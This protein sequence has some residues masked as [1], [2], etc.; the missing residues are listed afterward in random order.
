MECGFFWAVDAEV[1]EPTRNGLDSLAFL[2]GWRELAEVK[3]TCRAILL[4]HRGGTSRGIRS[5]LGK[6]I[7]PALPSPCERGG[8]RSHSPAEARPRPLPLA[9]RPHYTVRAKGSTR[10]L[11]HLRGLFEDGIHARV[12]RERFALLD[13]RRRQLAVLHAICLVGRLGVD[14]LA[15][16]GCWSEPVNRSGGAFS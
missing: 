11:G 9:I 4:W 5:E 8:R 10:I 13:P 14:Q 15:P 2:A 16:P 12:R 7:F 6:T 3:V 1:D